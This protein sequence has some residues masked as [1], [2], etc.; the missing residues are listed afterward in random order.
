VDASASDTPSYVLFVQ[1]GWAD[2]A[3][4]LRPLAR[5]LTTPKTTVVNPNLGFLQTWVRLE[6]LVQ[7]VE[8]EAQAAIAAAPHSLLRV[9][10]HSM[11]GLIWLEVLDRH[12]E[13]WT[14]V[15]GVVL[16]G[17]PI[18]GVDVAHLAD[19]LDLAIGR[20]LKVDRRPIA[21]RLA[22][23]IPLLSI[24]GK[25]DATSDG[26]VR[27]AE[28]TAPGVRTVVVP[29]VRHRALRSSR[30]VV[31]LCREFFRHLEPT[32]PPPADIVARLRTIPGMSVSRS[33][34]IFTPPLA[35][36]F[37]DGSALL[38]GRTVL[39]I[40]EVAYFAPDGTPRYAGYVGWSDARH[41]R[42]GLAALRRDYAASI[43]WASKR[44]EG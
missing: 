39:G 3:A 6:A 33:R 21:R 2:R 19:P 25:S 10:G 36:L 28:A 43:L 42:E 9:V 12:P 37:R 32:P 26:L 4:S 15:D 7:R 14:R 24:A 1:H 17:S 31:L 29:G 44:I 40:D 23:R 8:R 16:V 13:W 11:G 34:S 30:A 5:G 20:D 18:A 35:L 41:L 22:A 38:A 27:V